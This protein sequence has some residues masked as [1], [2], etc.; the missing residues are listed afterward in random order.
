[1]SNTKV[2]KYRALIL[3]TREKDVTGKYEVLMS[4]RLAVIIKYIHRSLDH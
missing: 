3:D 1:M 2:E 4:I